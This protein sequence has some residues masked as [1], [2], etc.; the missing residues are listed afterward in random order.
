M[1]S[2]NTSL[3]KLIFSSDHCLFCSIGTAAPG[4]S[5]TM[6]GAAHWAVCLLLDA[7]AHL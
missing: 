2:I 1:Y 3:Q 6:S 7:T 4:S 5:A